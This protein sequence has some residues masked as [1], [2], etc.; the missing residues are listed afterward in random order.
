MNSPIRMQNLNDE[1]MFDSETRYPV[2]FLN[3]G[4]PSSCGAMFVERMISIVTSFKI[5]VIISDQL[6]CGLSDFDTRK[7]YSGRTTIISG[8]ENVRVGRFLSMKMSSSG[9]T[10]AH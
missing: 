8:R 9:S 4:F 6:G 7:S 3:C 10:Q 5:L 2:L 1:S